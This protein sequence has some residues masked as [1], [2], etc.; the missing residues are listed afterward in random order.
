[1][2]NEKETLHFM[3][4]RGLIN[5]GEAAAPA[6]LLYFNDALGMGTAALLRFRLLLQSRRYS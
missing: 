6:S 1:M 5:A 4:L 3:R 2:E